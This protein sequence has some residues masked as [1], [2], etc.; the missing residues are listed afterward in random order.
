M[1]TM[2]NQVNGMSIPLVVQQLG[3]EIIRLEASYQNEHPVEVRQGRAPKVNHHA[4]NTVTLVMALTEVTIRM[5]DHA[6]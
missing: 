6:I 4:R 5:K 2:L 3:V 1:A